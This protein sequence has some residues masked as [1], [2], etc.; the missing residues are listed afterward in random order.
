MF[1]TFFCSSW[2]GFGVFKQVFT[3][4]TCLLYPGE[5][6]KLRLGVGRFLVLGVFKKFCVKIGEVHVCMY[7]FI[8]KN[9]S[10]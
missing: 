5:L 6:A 3:R 2:A 7:K 8:T 1:E 9:V 10:N 4:E